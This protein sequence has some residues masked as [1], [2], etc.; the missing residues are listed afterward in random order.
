M[1]IEA[2]TVITPRPIPV[3]YTSLQAI[4][5]SGGVYSPNLDRIEVRNRNTSQGIVT[6]T[7]SHISG[8][9]YEWSVIG[10]NVASI[11]LN[12]IDVVAYD[13]EGGSVTETFQIYVDFVA[14][15]FSSVVPSNN[16]TNRPTNN[17]IQVSFN[18][19]MSPSSVLSAISIS[20]A[21]A[22][23]TWQVGSTSD[24][25]S[26]NYSGYLQAYTTYTITITTDAKDAI[27]DTPQDDIY[28]QAGN[29]IAGVVTLNFT[30][31]AGIGANDPTRRGFNPPEAILEE[32]G[33][34][35]GLTPPE[36]GQ[37]QEVNPYAA[38]SAWLSTQ[39]ILRQSGYHG[40]VNNVDEPSLGESVAI[41]PPQLLNPFRYKKFKGDVPQNL[42]TGMSED[43]VDINDINKLGYFTTD[44][45][46]RRKEFS[47]I[48]YNISDS[49]KFKYIPKLLAYEFENKASGGIITKLQTR[50]VSMVWDNPASQDFPYLH[51]RV[52]I[53][54]QPSFFNSIVFDSYIHQDVF[55]A[56]D[57]G[58]TFTST[59]QRGMPSGRG[60]AKFLCP[61][62]LEA[63]IWY[64]RLR[65]G[66]KKY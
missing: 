19:Q 33:T 11:G 35:T 4:G 57:D 37:N 31:G 39:Y 44:Y 58:V 66:S 15:A 21:I 30:T 27:A 14:P 47:G 22:G 36:S 55:L 62:E 50:Q 53:S 43:S 25:Y 26:L 64:V 59:G 56:A 23:S 3:M 46:L 49:G 48:I 61:V 20:P 24:I 54:K 9:E 45:I 8:N 34:I 29:S 42:L 5:A 63:G 32:S 40:V 17:L 38:E 41:N 6:A 10:V 2:L 52:E 13:L 16:S 60:K 12:T 18:S 51:Y 1:S 65:V 28:I 7:T